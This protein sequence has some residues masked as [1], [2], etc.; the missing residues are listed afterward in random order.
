[1]D[2]GTMLHADAESRIQLRKHGA[3]QVDE[4][5]D[6]DRQRNPVQPEADR[7]SCSPVSLIVVPSV[8]RCFGAYQVI[9]PCVLSF[10]DPELSHVVLE[11]TQFRLESQGRQSGLLGRFP[12]HSEFR[13]LAGLHGPSRYL[14]SSVGEVCMF[15]HEKPSPVCDVGVHS[16]PLEYGHS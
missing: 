2:Q 16:A 1:M 6:T 9:E 8:W 5:W 11:V 15:E 3:L 7:V 14:Y 13:S 4:L 10:F 12:H